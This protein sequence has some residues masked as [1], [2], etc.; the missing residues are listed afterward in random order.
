MTVIRYGSECLE[1]GAEE[2]VLDCLTAQGAA[3]PFSC[4]SGLC[5]TCLM[6]AVSGK[7]PE[8]SQVGLSEALRLQTIF[9]PASVIPQKTWK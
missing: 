6:R 8:A 9:S 2:S 3:I 7:P 5:Q 4:R 1:I